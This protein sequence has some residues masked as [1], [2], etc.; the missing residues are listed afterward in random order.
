[1]SSGLFLVL[2]LASS[3]AWAQDSDPAPEDEAEETSQEASPEGEEGEDEGEGERGGTETRESGPGASPDARIVSPYLEERVIP[4]TGRR[5][6]SQTTHITT[7]PSDE[8][9]PAAA[10]APEVAPEPERAPTWED[11]TT[12]QDGVTRGTLAVELS[13]EGL[14]ELSVKRK[15]FPIYPDELGVMYGSDPIRCTGRAWVNDKGRAIRV[16]MVRCA[17]GF[18]AAALTA[19]SK[20]RWDAPEVVP[21]RG[22]QVEFELGF[23][24]KDRTFYPGITYFSDPTEVTADPSK[25]VLLRSGEM[26]S[27]PGQVRHGDAVCRIEVT[28]THKGKSKDILVDDCSSPYR[29]EAIKSLKKW[30][31]YPEQGSD[32]E[33]RSSTVVFDIAFRLAST[34][35]RDR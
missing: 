23:M 25:A 32:G 18:H 15:V 11:V 9:T 21:A 27:Y 28:V 4:V 10:E 24:R 3:G 34:V 30:R 5:D 29:A 6:A 35:G 26:P 7:S 31:W 8:E 1:M 17:D 2:L 20:W 14:V 33:Y 19:A 16:A 13:D 22:L 12:D